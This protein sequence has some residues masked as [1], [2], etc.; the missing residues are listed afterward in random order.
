MPNAVPFPHAT[1]PRPVHDGGHG[2]ALVLLHG[3]GATWEVWK[4]VL[5]ALEARHRVIAVTLPGHHGGVEFAGQ[6]DATVGAIAD[7]LVATLRGM[8]I[9]QAHVAG[10]SLGG[11][12]SL[13]L[14]RRGFAR[15]VVAFSPAG[16]WRSAEDYRAIATPFR[17]V[18]A[19][20][21]LILIL[22]GWLARFAWARRVLTRQTMVHGERMAPQEF[23]AAL[24]AMAN[25]RVLP[26]LLRTMGRDGPIAPVSASAAPITIAWGEQDR[27]IPYARYGAPF[28]DRIE[29]LTETVVPDAGHVPMWDNPDEVAA[30][31]LRVTATVDARQQETAAVGAT[32]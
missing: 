29:G 6:G 15:S 19:L 14:A 27:V 26:A 28:R 7:Q 3:M 11:W 23:R 25:T 16:A 10:N 31:I 21:G 4:P 12:L 5:P 24:R 13:E 22:F 18:Y 30:Q 9:E 32:A 17:I 20:I 8:G 2:T 1:V